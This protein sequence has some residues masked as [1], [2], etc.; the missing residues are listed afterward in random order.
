MSAS[1]LTHARSDSALTD[2]G[3]V[4]EDIFVEGDWR[5]PL[6][7]CTAKPVRVKPKNYVMEK[8]IKT[9]GKFQK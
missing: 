7:K 3:V 9:R 4:D 6:A 8:K 1:A 2:D 5:D